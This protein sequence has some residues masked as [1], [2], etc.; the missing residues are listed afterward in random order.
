M[1]ARFSPVPQ[2]RLPAAAAERSPPPL[3]PRRRSCCV[4]FPLVAAECPASRVPACL[5]VFVCVC[6]LFVFVSRCFVFV[7]VRCSLCFVFVFF[8]LRLPSFYKQ[9][10]RLFLLL[11]LLADWGLYDCVSFSIYR[12]HKPFMMMLS[13]L[14]L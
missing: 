1:L 13:L 4:Q 5:F 14:F 6:V 3:V 7:C 11:S 9:D 2:P 8:L 12:L 10:S